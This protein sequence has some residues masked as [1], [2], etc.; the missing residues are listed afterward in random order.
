[1]SNSSDLSSDEESTGRNKNK[2]KQYD[3]AKLFGQHP[4]IFEK[5]QIPDKLEAKNVA[6]QAICKK[7]QEIAGEEIT[8]KG[9]LKKMNNMKTRLKK[10]TDK[11]ERK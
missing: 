3:F 10:K 9:A 6:I 5:F 4:A 7:W 11:N 8:S 1:M 2:N